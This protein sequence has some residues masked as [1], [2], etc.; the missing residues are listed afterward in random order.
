[1]DVIV[2]AVGRPHARWAAVLADYEQRLQRYVRL[3][4]VTVREAVGQRRPE[5]ARSYEAQRIRAALPHPA[6]IVALDVAGA[7]MTSEAFAGEL[8]RW[9]ERRKPVV[10]VLGGPFGLDDSLRAAADVRLSLTPMTLP[11]DLARVVLLEQLYRA[12]TLWRGEPYHK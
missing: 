3:R 8:Q 1:M 4:V 12:M 11:H 2:I 6:T 5:D 9:I 7:L 10:F